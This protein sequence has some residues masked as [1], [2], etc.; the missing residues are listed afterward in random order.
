MI[1]E[2]A[3][4]IVPGILCV[5]GFL[6]WVLCRAA[7]LKSDA[8]ERIAR[9]LYRTTCDVCGRVWELTTQPFDADLGA[10]YDRTETC[11]AC[12]MH[13]NRHVDIDLDTT[14]AAD[15]RRMFDDG[16][17][18]GRVTRAGGRRS[19]TIEGRSAHGMAGSSA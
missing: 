1:G 4:T 17:S 13:A 6:T 16:I 3:T 14:S 5:S 9:T 11:P 19:A 8:E 2:N 7:A 12:L 10:T 15:I 18:L